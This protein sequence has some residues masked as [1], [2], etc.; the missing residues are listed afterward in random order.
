M[1][2]IPSMAGLGARVSESATLDGAQSPGTD[3]GLDRLLT[4]LRENPQEV[5]IRS[6]VRTLL[7]ECSHDGPIEEAVKKLSS[8]INELRAVVRE[9]LS[10]ERVALA[11]VEDLREE[12]DPVAT[13]LVHTLEQ[14]SNLRGRLRKLSEAA[15][16]LMDP[17]AKQEERRL[18]GEVL[19]AS[20]GPAAALFVPGKALRQSRPS[21]SAR[22]VQ[23]CINSQVKRRAPDGRC[24]QRFREFL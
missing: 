4:I 2:L 10:P 16:G 7:R 23:S 24:K 5:R 13:A 15:T 21:A 20:V 17:A 22:I 11:T 6:A 1:A 3:S 19:E 9:R 14:S 12:A 18:R 8:S